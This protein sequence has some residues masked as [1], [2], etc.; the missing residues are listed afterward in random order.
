MATLARADR[1]PVDVEAAGR[2]RQLRMLGTMKATQEQ[3]AAQLEAEGHTRQARMLRSGASA[4]KH[5][6][7]ELHRQANRRG[8]VARVPVDGPLTFVRAASTVARIPRRGHVGPRASRPCAR[9]MARN[10]SRGGESGDSDDPEPAGP[11]DPVGDTR[12]V[13][14]ALREG[15]VS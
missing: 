12:R 2:A 1:S 10:S 8:L 6:E 3:R 13:V 11:G 15:A 7:R 5:M 14:A 4:T 9:A